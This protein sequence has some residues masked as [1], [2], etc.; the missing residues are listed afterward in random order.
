MQRDRTM[1]RNTHRTM[2]RNR[3]RGMT[4]QSGITIKKTMQRKRNRNRHRKRR[5]KQNR[6]KKRMRTCIWHRRG[7]RRGIGI[8]R[9][10]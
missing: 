5:M 10:I 4:R 7:Q 6:K 9:G 8:G 2:K 3:R 1:Q